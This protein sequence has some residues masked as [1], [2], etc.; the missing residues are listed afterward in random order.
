MDLESPQSYG[1]FYWAAQAE[2]R[3]KSLEDEGEQ[4]KGYI[5]N[6]FS[7]PAIRENIPFDFL[8]K[9][10]ALIAS[11]AAALA[12]IGMRFISE[13]ADS[14]LG[15]TMNHALKAFNYS[16]ASKFHDENI[17]IGDSAQLFLRGWITDDL[18]YERMLRRGYEDVE[19]DLYLKAQTPYPTI[20]ELMQ[21]A[22]YH[23]DPE[24]VRDLVWKKFNVPEADFDM[25]EWLTL[26]RLPSGVLTKL[27][28]RGV[29]EQS[30]F[31]KRMAQIGFRDDT[32]EHTLEDSW[33][34]PN[35]M[36]MVQGGLMQNIET[37]D[38][39]KSIS[40]A[41]IH[42]DYS[43][44]YLDAILTKPSTQDVIAY[45]LRQDPDLS[46]LDGKLRRVGVHSEY[47]DVYRT[48]AYQIPPVADI[49]TMAVREAF[50]PDIA[51]RFGQYE[52]Y[53]D[54][55]TEWGQKKGLTEEWTKRYWAA[56][57]SLP[58]PQQGF[59]ML[60]RGII[61][62]DELSMLLRA[63]D[64]MPYWR[65]RLT[66]IAFRP[67]TR[68]DVR[69]MYK[70]GILDETGVYEAYLDHGYKPENAQRMTEFTIRYVLTQQSKFTSGDVVAAF[71]KRMISHGQ[72]SSLLADLGIEG[73]SISYILSTAEYKREWA[74]T[75]SKISGIRNLY[76]R[77]VYD[78]NKARD[79]L[80]RLNLPAEQ[81]NVLI[82]QWWYEDKTLPTANWTK[83]ETFKFIKAGL[84]TRDRGQQ[85]LKELGFD[86]EHISVYLRA[87]K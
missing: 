79:E 1:E 6:I 27:L 70:E 7:D 50:T 67:L 58:S 43:Q 13:M 86:D 78:E 51:T 40:K 48:L 85:E 4:T 36:L 31:D 5:P 74:L 3:I 57:W 9:W 45:E 75:E 26:Q 29:I 32:V 59:Q 41:D 18:F 83:A 46:D 71:T 30:D 81:I 66:E 37:E 68:V 72:A 17:T 34:L 84:I 11:P 25:Y 64:V 42:P 39:L 24:N 62:R 33:L 44:T 2:A 12:P 80:S 69:R 16:V 73:G 23:G 63:L 19:A 56:H 15:D 52:D 35:A 28:R 65:D 60:H 53:P 87:I 82:Q 8:D 14:I 47:A 22:R 54:Q 38:L 20:A 76:K 21:W 55:L 49:I 77:A 10:D 61:E